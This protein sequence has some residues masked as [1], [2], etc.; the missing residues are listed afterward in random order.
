[1]SL[2]AI[3]YIVIKGDNQFNLK[4]LKETR[5]KIISLGI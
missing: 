3:R 5:Q 2:Q 4:T 1:M